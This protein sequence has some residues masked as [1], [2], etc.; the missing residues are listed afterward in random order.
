MGGGA[1]PPDCHHASFPAVLAAPAFCEQLRSRITVD[2]VGQPVDGLRLLG[3][4]LRRDVD[5][6]PV[7]DVAPCPCRRGCGRTLAAQPLDGAVLGAGR[8]RAAAWSRSASA[9]RRPRRGSPR[10][11]S[12]GP[13]PRG[14]RRLRLNTGSP[15]PGDHVEVARLR[16]RG[17]PRSPLPASRTRLP[18][19]TPAGMLTRS[20]RTLRWAPL[21]P[22]VGHGSSITVPAAVGTWSRAGRSRRSPGPGPRRR[23][24][25]TPG[26]PWAWCRA[27]RRCRDRSG[28]A[29]GRHR[30]RH[31]GAVDRLVEGQRDLGLEVAAALRARPPRRRRDRRGPRP[32]RRRAEQVREDVAEVAGE[33]ARVEAAA[34]PAAAANG[35]VPRSYCLR[36][37]GSDEHVVR[38]GDLL[39]ALLGLLVARVAVG[40]VLARELAVG[41]LDL[42]VAGVLADAERLVVVGSAGHRASPFSH[43][44]TTRAGR[45]TNSP[46]RSRA[47]RPRRPSRAA[48][49]RRAAARS[50]R[51]ARGRT[52]RPW[53]SS[54]R[55]PRAQ[56]GDQLGVYELDALDTVRG[57]PRCRARS[58]RARGRGCRARAAAPCASLATPRS[59][60]PRPS[61]VAARLR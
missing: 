42:L 51:G 40:V 31:L 14:S 61:R 12:A 25:R 30:Q 11:S 37:S 55:S 18:S 3:R 43:A 57:R 44:T 52:A 2:H 60:A 9:P 33:R 35:P 49:P 13:R 24:P 29:R 27:W 39:E 50:P 41:L 28:T 58:P 4:Q 53:A 36:F 15:H 20:L 5:Q 47:G 45:I 38:L 1:G 16:R 54:A 48:R 8:R 23:G 56:R 6:E 7:A 21:P 59:C 34:A 17:A 46:S 22:Q 26:R 10:G 19:W 32:G